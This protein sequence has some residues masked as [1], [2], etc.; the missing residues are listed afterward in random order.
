MR[1]FSIY[2]VSSL[3]AIFSCTGSAKQ[4]TIEKQ[5]DITFREKQEQASQPNQT[6]VHNTQKIS[7]AVDFKAAVEKSTPAVV[8]VKSKVVPSESKMQEQ[9]EQIPEPFRDF[10]RRPPQRDEPLTRASGSGVI[11]SDDGYIATNYHLLRNADKM[12]VTLYDNR[13]FDAEVVG[14]DPATDL[15]LLKI[16]EE[17]LQFLNFGNSDEIDVGSWVLAVGNPFNLSSTVTAGI[18]SAKARN[19]NILRD[20]GA[21]ESFIQTDAAVNPGNSGG[22]LVNLDGEL[23]GINTAI[24]SPTGTYAG[25]AFAIPSNIVEKVMDDL[26]QY[27]TVQRAYLGVYIRSMNSELADQLD[28]DITRGVYLDSIMPSSAAEDAGLKKEDIIISVNGEDINSAPKLQEVIGRKR[29]GEKVS[30][31]VIRNGKEKEFNI[32]LKNK[33][34]DTD[35]VEKEDLSVLND[36]GIEVSNISEEEKEDLEI[37]GGVK[38]TSIKR[39]PVSQQTNMKEGF[40]I[41]R[42]DKKDVNNLEDL[43]RILRNAEDGIM[44]EGYYPGYDNKFFYAFGI[45]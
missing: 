30:I 29:P 1:I 28:V 43:E 3:L 31:T 14:T 39:G 15:A 11:I 2:L 36:I 13:S 17:G 6:S 21:I 35:I 45:D 27:G 24:A 23:I 12:T 42:A 44:V 41:V 19:I 38:V 34:G 33:R 20:Q 26:L 18:V 22:A 7:E 16:D 10:F 5:T 25:Y 4:E 40:V 32:T 9:Y 8:H 37:D